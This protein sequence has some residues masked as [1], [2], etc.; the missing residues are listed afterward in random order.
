VLQQQLA[1]EPLE[2]QHLPL[3][4]LLLLPPQMMPLLLLLS[5]QVL[6]VRH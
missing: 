4:L 5:L 2:R 1:A 6:V 3:L